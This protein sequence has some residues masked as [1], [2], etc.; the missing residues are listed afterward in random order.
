MFDGTYMRFGGFQGRAAHEI[1]SLRIFGTGFWV[2]DPK[3]KPL[4]RTHAA[5]RAA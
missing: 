2:D 3:A 5:E 4:S 1:E